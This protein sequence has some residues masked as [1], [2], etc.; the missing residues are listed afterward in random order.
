[1][2]ILQRIWED[3]K[4]GENIDLYITIF[5]SPIIIILNM[6]GITP[7]SLVSQV[8]F[9][10][11]ALIAIAMLKNRRNLEKIQVSIEQGNSIMFL[12][13]SDKMQDEL[14]KNIE[15][16]KNLLLI[17]SSFDRIL[18][19]HHKRIESKLNR[20]DTVRAVI[21]NPDS[22]TIDVI[23]K[24]EKPNTP[25]RDAELKRKKITATVNTLNILKTKTRGKLE[26]R[27]TDVPLARGGI[28]TDIDTAK[29]YIFLWDNC[30][31][32][33]RKAKYVVRPSDHSWYK[34]YSEEANA[35]WDASHM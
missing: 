6:L 9:G 26:I 24:R 22:P 20:G 5:V 21:I 29:G 11:F 31:Q 7:Q 14:N 15:N 25:N 23:V 10:M 12:D 8:T 33:S 3:L 27:F 16:C 17:G 32:C 4:Q 34:Y 1:M 19:L 13:F 18:H 2:P 30:Y 35:I 28:Y